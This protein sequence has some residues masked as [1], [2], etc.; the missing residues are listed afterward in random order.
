VE[1]K[2]ATL[3]QCVRLAVADLPGVL[4][5]FSGPTIKLLVSAREGVIV[6]DTPTPRVARIAGFLAWQ[7]L[8]CLAP[9]FSFREAPA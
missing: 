6:K 8:L 9:H 5:N 4:A 1:Y 7:G 3:E 2:T